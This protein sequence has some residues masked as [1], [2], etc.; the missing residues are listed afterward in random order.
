M[1][2]KEDISRHKHLWTLTV[3]VLANTC[4]EDRLLLSLI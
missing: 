1:C 2:D 4:E 3:K